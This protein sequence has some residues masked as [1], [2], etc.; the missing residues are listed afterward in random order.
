MIAFLIKTC[1]PCVNFLKASMTQ[2][3]RWTPRYTP[4]TVPRRRW[5]HGRG[6]AP[7]SDGSRCGG[8]GTP[9]MLKSGVD[10]ILKSS[11]TLNS[12]G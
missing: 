3:Y 5:N 2:T 6:F 10:V 8:G 1:F 9:G 11:R 4:K 12:A 7:A